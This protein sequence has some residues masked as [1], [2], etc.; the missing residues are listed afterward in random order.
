MTFE[1]NLWY[2]FVLE[3]LSFSLVCVFV[4]QK[5]KKKRIKVLNVILRKLQL[6]I[7]LD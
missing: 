6:T 4:S 1:W 3:P 2:A 7:L 5:K